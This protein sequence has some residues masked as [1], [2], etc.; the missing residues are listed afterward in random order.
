MIPPRAQPL[1][2]RFAV[3]ATLILPT[4]GVAGTRSLPAKDAPEA[5]ARLSTPPSPKV[6]DAAPD[7]IWSVMPYGWRR[8]REL[9]TSGPQVL[10]LEPTAAQL[11][12]VVRESAALS[13]RGA[14]L[15]VVLQRDADDRWD[16]IQ[17]LGLQCRLLS[18]PQAQV[19]D[20]LGVR[21][22]RTGCAQP[23]WF[24][25]D[26]T[27]TLRARGSG[28]P[29]DALPGDVAAALTPPAPMAA[30]GTP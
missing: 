27:G 12:D 18:D 22:P 21:D 2:L 16:A 1:L 26:R 6:G 4:A 19:A 15:I 29:V 13:A 24:V 14:S 20:S 10:V 28:V 25:M 3:L 23:S 8:L 17:R 11:V 9:C 30:D 5:P 7:L